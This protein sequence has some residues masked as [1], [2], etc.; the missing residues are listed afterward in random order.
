LPKFWKKRNR[1]LSCLKELGYKVV[2]RVLDAV[3][4]IPQHR[5]RLFILGFDK[6]MFGDVV[7]FN[8]PVLPKKKMTL[9]TILEKRVD[10]KYVLSDKL[11]KYLQDYAEKHR[12]K[13]NGFGY[14]LFDRNDVA[15]TLSA[16]YYKDGSEI[17]IKMHNSNPRRLTPREC[18][19][20]MGF[21]DSFKIPVSDTQAYR[22]FGNSVAV[23]VVKAV[24]AEFVKTCL[25]F[26]PE[27][28]PPE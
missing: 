8:F 2:S 26:F 19:R 23:P 17:L 13:G 7:D 5:E 24:A 3:N 10:S 22:Q 11:W 27:A 20:L 28:S 9:K 6:K 18:A 1:K 12:Q 25:P 16:R 15:R 14:G 21:D 4:Y